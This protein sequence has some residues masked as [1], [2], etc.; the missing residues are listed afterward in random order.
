M[1]EQVAALHLERIGYR[2]IA[3]NVRARMGEIDMVAEQGGYVVFVEVKTRTSVRYGTAAEAVTVP[4]QRQLIRLAERFLAIHGWT[5][6]PCRFD[7]VTVT[8]NPTGE[9][10]CAVIMD[11]F[12]A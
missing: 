11:A 10:T 6:R 8:L 5:D 2:V 4:K 3:R 9:W 1:G 7:V 12:G